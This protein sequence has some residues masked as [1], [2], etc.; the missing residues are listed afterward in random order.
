MA[1]ITQQPGTLTT[2]EADIQIM[3]AAEV[4]LGTKNCDNSVGNKSR[5]LKKSCRDEVEKMHD[6]EDIQEDVAAEADI[7]SPIEMEEKNKIDRGKIKK[8]KMVK[9]GRSSED[10]SHEKSEKRVKFSGQVQ[11]LPSLSD[12]KHEIEEEN[13]LRGKRFSKL[14]DEIVKE[15]VHKYIEIH[16]LGEEGLK[17]VLNARS[18]PKIKG[19][20]KEIGRAIPYRPSTAV[21]SRA[22][23]LFRRSESRKWTEEEY[24]MVRKFQKEHG[25]NWRILADE[26]GKHRWHVKDTWR[27]LKLPNQN[28]GQWTQEEYQNLFDLVNTDLRLKLS[29][30][31]KSNHGMLQDNIAWGVISE[32]LSTRTNANCCLKWYQGWLTQ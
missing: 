30:E 13:L 23:I 1:A 18:Y 16:N 3:L 22:Q 21:Y 7:S 14:E 11:I 28:K 29:E 12:E 27:R 26:L 31:K 10:P 15:A 32:N 9:L 19:C 24:E 8:R 20:W 6:T 2:K 5:K 25:N 4:H 17:K